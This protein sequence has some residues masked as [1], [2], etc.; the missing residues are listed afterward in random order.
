MARKPAA[1][2]ATAVFFAPAARRRAASILGRELVMDLPP[3]QRRISR[4]SRPCLS[5]PADAAAC[6]PGVGG[7]VLGNHARGSGWLL[8]GSGRLLLAAF[9]FIFGLLRSTLSDKETTRA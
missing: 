4:P 5:Q 9:T 3:P 7:T 2:A 1:A 6:S 8:L